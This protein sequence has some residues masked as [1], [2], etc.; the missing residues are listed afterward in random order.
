MLT[1][2]LTL[3]LTPVLSFLSSDPLKSNSKQRRKNEINES[4]LLTPFNYINT[5]DVHRKE[6]KYIIDALFEFLSSVDP[7]KSDENTG[8]T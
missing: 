8:F 2:V 1:P 6:D 5:T 7:T 3:V 4:L